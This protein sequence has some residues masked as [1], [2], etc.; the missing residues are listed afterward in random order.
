MMLLTISALFVTQAYWFKK[1]FSLHE[2]QLDEKLNVALR[3]VAHSLLILDKDSTSTIPPV[4]KTASNEYFVN[5]SCYFSLATL[6]SCIRAEFSSRKMDI[7]FDYLIL[8]SEEKQVLLGNTLSSLFDTTVVACKSRLD[9]KETLDFK[10][11]INNKNTYLLNSMG[12]WMFSSLSLLAILAI[13]TFISI[14]IIK[15]KKLDALKKDFVNNMTHELKTPI[16]NISVASEAIRNKNIKMDEEKLTKYADIISKEN[17]RLHNLVDSVLQIFSIEK[18]AETFNFKLV[19][20]HELIKN[21]S[22]NFE[23]LLQKRKGS[24]TFKLNATQFKVQADELHLSNV[25]YNLIDNAIK[26]SEKNPEITIQTSNNKKGINF[27]ISDKGIGINKENQQRIFEK[28][29]R[30][31]TGNLH[32]T[33]GH[34]LGLSYVKLIVEKHKGLITFESK[35]NEGSSFNIFLPI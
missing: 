30:A 11:R 21:I 1:S 15:G 23:P 35:L 26:Y 27:E 34:G 8:N 31:E 9:N 7:K 13:F 10:I 6:D 22:M 29:Y 32:N 24:V 18:S 17:S 25:I 14:K 28:F 20:L 3:N 5:T 16:A 33:K 19:N 2:K 12:I 4:S